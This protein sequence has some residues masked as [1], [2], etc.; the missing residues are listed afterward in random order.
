MDTFGISIEKDNY[1]SWQG[2]GNHGYQPLTIMING[3]SL[4]DL[5][6][7][8][9]APLV[10]KENEERALPKQDLLKAGDYMELS[11]KDGLWPSKTLL[12]KPWNSVFK[13]END[14]PRK[15]KSL[16]LSCSSGDEGSWPLL[17]DIIVKENKII[18]Q[19]FCQFHRE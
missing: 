14:D 8:V 13:L 19:E 12:G 9:E 1:I 17:V 3:N 2:N 15:H 11:A 4:L 10:K 7:K 5:I 6:K 18:W 16:I